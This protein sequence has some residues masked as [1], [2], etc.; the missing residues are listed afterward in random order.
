[1]DS[2]GSKNYDYL[3]HTFGEEKIGERFELLFSKSE[4]LIDRFCSAQLE[5]HLLK[6]LFHVN[7][8]LIQ[9]IVIN[10]FADID[11][12]KKFHGIDKVNSIKI[13]AYTAYWYAKLR[14]VHTKKSIDPEILNK[15]RK[16]I[17]KI[18]EKVALGISFGIAFDNSIQ[19]HSSPDTTELYKSIV[20]SLAYRVTTPQALELMIHAHICEPSSPT[21]NMED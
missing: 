7:E 16:L 10:Y 4:E 3:V 15:Y 1:M 17:I 18:N 8:L 2:S 19:N 5:S 14:P 13:A 12:L 20:Y 9:D 6:G 11:R 21:L